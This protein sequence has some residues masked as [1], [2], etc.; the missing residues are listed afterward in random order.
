MV[1]AVPI[2]REVF[3]E[4]IDVP[5]DENFN[6][7]FGLQFLGVQA[8]QLRCVRKLELWLVGRVLVRVR[9]RL[10][11]IFSLGI[12]VLSML[13]WMNFC[14]RHEWMDCELLSPAVREV[15]AWFHGVPP[16][17]ANLHRYDGVVIVGVL[18]EVEEQRCSAIVELHLLMAE[19]IRHILVFRLLD[20]V[21][22]EE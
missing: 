11:D 6:A 9:A 20:S 18:F 21:W 7:W 19:A 1:L 8:K 17:I 14:G 10:A 5:F 15:K 16:A 12:Q 2:L 3:E 13:A 22:F 4:D